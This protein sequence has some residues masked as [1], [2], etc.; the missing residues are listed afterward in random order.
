MSITSLLFK[1]KPVPVKKSAPASRNAP[2]QYTPLQFIPGTNFG[3]QVEEVEFNEFDRRRTL[4]GRNQSGSERR[5][6]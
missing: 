5:G 2:H 6:R 3:I 1:K 4:L